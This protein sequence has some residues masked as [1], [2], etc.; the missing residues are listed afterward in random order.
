MADHIHTPKDG[1]GRRDVYLDGVQIKRVT[2][3]DTRCGVVRIMYDP[4]KLCLRR[5]RAR[6]FKRRG[7]VVVV[8]RG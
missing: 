1:R 6:T 2:Y 3:A 5:E 8:S 7:R 4:L